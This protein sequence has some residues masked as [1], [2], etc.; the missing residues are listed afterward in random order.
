MYIL[1]IMSNMLYFFPSSN[2]VI[3]VDVA[4]FT[5]LSYVLR[6]QGWRY[7]VQFC[8]LFL[9]ISICPKRKGDGKW[10]CILP[11]FNNTVI[12][13]F[14][15]EYLIN[16][17]N[18]SVWFLHLSKWQIHTFS[19]LGAKSGATVMP[20]SPSYHIILIHI[21]ADHPNTCIMWPLL[22]KSTITLLQGYQMDFYSNLHHAKPASSSELLLSLLLLPG[23]L[24]PHHGSL[25]TSLVPDSNDTTSEIFHVHPR[26]NSSLLIP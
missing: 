25:S 6:E 11:M 14:R 2:C 24:F 12:L 1:C 26:S 4:T 13:L 5:H 10:D 15:D 21:Q 18:T 19:C 8:L 16:K 17:P 22:T 23:M 9:S 7:C 20:V 3:R